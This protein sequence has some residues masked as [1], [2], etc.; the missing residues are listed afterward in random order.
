[1]PRLALTLL[2]AVAGAAGAL[3]GLPVRATAQSDLDALMQKVLARRDDNWKKL[4]QYIL[5]ENERIDVRGPVNMPIWGERRD[6]SW[7]IRDGYF[8]RSPL[9]VNGVTIS[10]A[11]RRKEEDEYFKRAQ[12]RDK[13]RARAGSQGRGGTATADATPAAAAGTPDEP[14]VESLIRQTRQPEFM[15]SAY[16]LRFKFE[17]GKYAFVGRE[18]ME[19]LDVLKIEYYPTRLFS[20]DQDREQRAASAGKTTKGQQEDAAYEKMMNKV[21]LVTIWVEP[22]ASQIVKYT[23]DNINF[24]FF[25][26]AWLVRVKDLKASMT[27]S[28]P[29][30]DA[31]DAAKDIWLPRDV[32]F[33]FSAMIAIGS[34]DARLHLDYKNYQEAKTAAHIREPGRGRQ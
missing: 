33:Y 1:V 32:D 18:K 13:Q 4:Q 23:F 14:N 26:G 24:D 17:Q 16:F 10:E 21:S 31:K 27:M 8:I 15:D 11:E 9:K 29:F 19:G 22:T 3:A 7:F 6:Y 25:P 28:K 12:E 2:L 5:D 20:H 30:K 34:V